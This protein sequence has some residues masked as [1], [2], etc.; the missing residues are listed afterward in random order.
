MSL[1]VKYLPGCG[2]GESDCCLGGTLLDELRLRNLR[3]TQISGAFWAIVWSR[4]FVSFGLADSLDSRRSH[5]FF[6]STM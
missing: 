6:R 2:P 5:A 3:Q 1:L 4:P